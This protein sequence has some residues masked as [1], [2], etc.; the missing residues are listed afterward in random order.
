MRTVLIVIVSTILSIAGTLLFIGK[1][2][3]T[4][5]HESAYDRVMRTGTIRCAYG[6]ARPWIIKDPNSGAMSGLSVKVMEAVAKH[7]S[8]KLDWTQETGWGDLAASL[9][10]GRA[11]VACS[12][13]WIQAA[14]ARELTFTRPYMYNALYA[15]SRADDARF[16]GDLSE[17]NQPNVRFA[18]MDGDVTADVPRV[19]FPNATIVGIPS[20]GDEQS[21]LQVATNKA[22]LVIL[23]ATN[24]AAFNEHNPDTPL[25]RVPTAEPII[26]FG[27]ALAVDNDELKLRDML[28][29]TL[30]EM[31]GSGELDRIIDELLQ[32]YPDALLRSHAS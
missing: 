23:D 1:D 24:V 29:A 20:G 27:S 11:D 18:G 31:H 4:T 7:L 12:G 3:Q 19:K 25:K 26:S 15:F 6:I 17:L 28:D 32:K 16:T 8:L 22:D 21:L 9:S 13:L 30:T 2:A 14:Q 5:A 10:S